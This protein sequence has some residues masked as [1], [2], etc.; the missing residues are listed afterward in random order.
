MFKVGDRVLIIKGIFPKDKADQQIVE[1]H[2]YKT[3]MKVT[4][5]NSNGTVQVNYRDN[6]PVKYL[7]R[8][9]S[10]HF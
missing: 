7:R 3:F 6:V 10:N 9:K 2:K 8:E 5:I 1:R 4:R